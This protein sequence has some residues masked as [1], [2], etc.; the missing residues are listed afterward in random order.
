[1]L[2]RLIHPS[3]DELNDVVSSEVGNTPCNASFSLPTR[4][5]FRPVCQNAP[6]GVMQ[7]QISSDGEAAADVAPRSDPSAY[8][9][10]S[11]AQREACHSR[12][13]MV[14]AL[15]LQPVSSSSR[16]WCCCKSLAQVDDGNGATCCHGS[17]SSHKIV[18]LQVCDDVVPRMHRCVGRVLQKNK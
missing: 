3:E 7:W 9:Q 15:R 16:W 2:S 10:H 13:R 18:S 5:L 4:S 8:S 14:T 12:R 17:L 1:M 6:S 11:A